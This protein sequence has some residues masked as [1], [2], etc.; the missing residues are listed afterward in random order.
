[1]P[2]KTLLPLLSL[3]GAACPLPAEPLPV[4]SFPI[5]VTREDKPITGWFEPDSFE[6][7]SPK[8]HVLVVAGLQA[9]DERSQSLAR[10]L[11]RAHFA[12][13]TPKP[14]TLSVILDAN[15]DDVPTPPFPPT[16]KA[17]NDQ[18]HPHALYLH[19]FLGAHGPDLVIDLRPSPKF[20]L[21]RTDDLGSGQG[22]EA[23]AQVGYV[24]TLRVEAGGLAAPALYEKLQPLLRKLNPS[25]ARLELQDRAKRSATNVARQ[26]AKVYGHDAKTQYIPALALVGRL[27]LSDLTDDTSHSQDVER[28]LRP[29]ASGEKQALGR[30]VS[31]VNLAGH[32]A[33]AELALRSKDPTLVRLVEAAAQ[34]AHESR[35]S[36][37]SPVSGHNE[38]SD[39]VFMVCPILAAA[40]RLT[41]NA[42]HL[43]ALLAHLRHLRKLCLRKDNLYR[44]SP[45]D[46]SAWGR[47][48]GFPALGLALVLSFLPEDSPARPEILDAHLAHLKALLR[49]QDHSGAF[50][51][52]V[53]RPQS[54]RE[55]TVTAM[56]TFALCRGLRKG[57]LDDKTFA[58]PAHKAWEALKL[59]IAP[60]GSLLDVCA[61]TGKQKN[62]RAY[63]DRPAILG[64]DSRG[65][66]MALLAATEYAAWKKEKH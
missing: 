41:G 61:G 31:G 59:R 56:T 66:A 27:R 53:D 17:Y 11:L 32:L 46:E 19:R 57:W 10:D 38:M 62:L 65:G 15:P 64:R 12:S 37:S 58:T 22:K 16:G 29:Y 26:L 35:K 23:P 33:L 3:L 51:Q 50:H 48:N 44:H 34:R 9:G 1:M 40:H 18:K 24:P 8:K 42:D 28:L 52:V 30:G 47:G 2:T 6:V 20:L 45:L 13:T 63:F 25:P 4:L 36:P 60:D 39:S 43:A 49:H 55:L 21:R 5:G 7:G 14:F 54:Y